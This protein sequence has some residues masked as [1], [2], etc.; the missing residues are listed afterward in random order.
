MPKFKPK[1]DILVAHAPAYTDPVQPRNT[2]VF[3]SCSDL[4]HKKNY[5]N[6]GQSSKQKMLNH[7]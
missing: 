3:T 6:S 5:K 1:N 4:S 7:F 2:T